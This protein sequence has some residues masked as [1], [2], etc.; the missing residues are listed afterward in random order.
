MKVEWWAPRDKPD[1]IFP[2]AESL[3]ALAERSDALFIASRAT[4]E[5]ARQI[6]AAV[7]QALGP[8]GILVNVSRGFLVDE[9]A[10]LAALTSGAVGGA[11]LD[12]FEQEPVSP[13]RWNG[14]P[15]TVL[16]PHIAG[17]TREAGVDMRHQQH[18]NVRRHFAGEPL[19]TPVHDP[20]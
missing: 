6:D 9:D 20:L 10:L 12:V 11:A 3:M 19:L 18:E 14:V 13:A 15:G 7:L 16:T 17:F 2:R 5:N 1:A 4:P 8:H